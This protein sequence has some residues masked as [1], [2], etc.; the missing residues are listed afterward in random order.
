MKQRL[1]S[2]AAGL[3][4]T[5]MID[6]VFQLVIFFAV[7]IALQKES[8]RDD[9]R[10]PKASHFGEEGR[11]VQIR[12]QVGADGVLYIGRM[13]LTLE[14]IRKHIATQAAR[15]GRDRISVT[16]YADERAA[17]RSVAP[18]LNACSRVGVGVRVAARSAP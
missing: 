13:A 17:H 3:P 4:L 9:I 2:A 5:P 8:I 18:V 1:R 11:E 12:V 15:L 14:Q 10:L 16:V 7:A 6:I